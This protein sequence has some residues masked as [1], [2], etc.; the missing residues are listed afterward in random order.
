L[1]AE[2][3][4]QSLGL[5]GDWKIIERNYV[6]IEA[7]GAGSFGKVVKARCK[8]TDIVVAV[9]F[10]DEFADYNYDCVKILREICL[11]KGV[12]E[13]SKNGSSCYFPELIDVVLPI[14]SSEESIRKIFIVM[15][16]E[17]SDL[18]KLLSIGK[19]CR[20]EESHVI[21]IMYNL[22]CALKYMHSLN[23]VHRDIKPS[24][25]LINKDCQIKICDLGLARTL[26]E[27]CIGGGSGN[28]KRIRDSILKHGYSKTYSKQG[29][30]DLVS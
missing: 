4:R 24:N 29:L 26:P 13:N 14:G 16:Y 30:R 7:I 23:I 22:L 1:D 27:S 9:K 19:K 8:H 2:S 20:L 6:L 25:I 17:S 15:E 21:L 12:H 18:R 28:S 10:I 3:T 5:S 11:L